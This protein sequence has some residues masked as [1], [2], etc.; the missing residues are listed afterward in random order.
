MAGCVKIV[1]GKENRKGKV[2]GTYAV[3]TRKKRRKKRRQRK[4]FHVERFHARLAF[5]EA[6]SRV[7]NSPPSPHRRCH[8]SPT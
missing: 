6:G 2:P 8:F 3:Y 4:S 5:E 1:E 7:R